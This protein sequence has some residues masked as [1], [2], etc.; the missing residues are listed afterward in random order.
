MIS[1]QLSALIRQW[2][3]EARATHP[4]HLTPDG[5]AVLIY[6]DMGGA[7]YVTS[8]GEILTQP[9]DADR[10]QPEPDPKLRHTALVIGA[11]RRP[12]LKELLPERSPSDTDCSAC[13]GTGWLQFDAARIVCGQCGGLGW[14]AAT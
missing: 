14:N 10:A 9:W 7:A 4:S 11:R 13:S 12:E 3:D 1:S 2:I 5:R 6:G 8:D